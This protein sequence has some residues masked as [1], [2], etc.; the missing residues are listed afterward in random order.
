MSKGGYVYIVTNKA[1]TVLYIGVTANLSVRSYEHKFEKGSSF[2]SKYNCTDVVFYQFYDT[3]EEAIDREK[4]LKNWHRKWKINLIKTS[5]PT[6]K[7]LFDDVRDL[8]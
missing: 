4:Q 6:F 5:N 7:D 2:T 8:V 1:R 3:I